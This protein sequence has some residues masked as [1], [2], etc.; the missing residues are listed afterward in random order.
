[1]DTYQF[2]NHQRAQPAD[3]QCPNLPLTK[4]MSLAFTLRFSGRIEG[5]LGS[6]ACRNPSFPGRNAI[7]FKEASWAQ[8]LVPLRYNDHTPEGTSVQDLIHMSY[9]IPGDLFM[10]R[11][12]L[13]VTQCPMCKQKPSSM[14]ATYT[15]STY[16]N[17]IAF[18]LLPAD[19]EVD[20]QKKPSVLHTSSFPCDPQYPD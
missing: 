8:F 14:T 6:C 2:T 20:D 16:G 5:L 15:F 10:A 12:T 4:A 1:M 3:M 9:W 13:E 18:Y 17:V 19:E 11:K 7:C